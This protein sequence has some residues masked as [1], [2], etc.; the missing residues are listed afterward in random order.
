MAEF[1]TS[2]PWIAIGWIFLK[3][4]LAASIL[5]TGAAIY[6]MM[7]RK[8]LGAFTYRY[9]PNR[10]GPGGW[11][12]FLPDAI[13]MML[14]EDIIP[15]KADKLVF[16]LAP[17]IFM[18]TAVASLAI[19][20]WGPSDTAF[21]YYVADPN[22]GILVFL[23]IGSISVYG[24]ALGGWASQSKYS[25]M[26]SLRSTA[27]MI[28]YELS[29]GM[30][31]IGVII[32]AG[33]TRLTDI[34]NAQ[35]VVPFLFPQILGFVVYFISALAETS[36]SPF[37]LPEAESELVGGYF[38]EYSGMRFGLYFLGELVAQIVQACLISLMFFGGW[39]AIFPLNLIPGIEVIPGTLWFVLKVILTIMTFIWIRATMPR[40]RYDRLM[41][42]GWKFLL[43]LS[44]VNLIIQAVWVALF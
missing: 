7:M 3:A 4:I 22:A 43:P 34:V 10:V 5:L 25:L 33:S 36:H 27:Q 1:L 9:G 38:T 31:V 12:Q 29:M 13:K 19:I 17:I 40:F 44:A 20:P 11:L 35:S 2:S 24:V 42:F 14:K 32:A 30:A 6:L 8:G 16:R 21:S 39:H 28:S 37:D 15:E 41:T 26:G 18:F 23:A